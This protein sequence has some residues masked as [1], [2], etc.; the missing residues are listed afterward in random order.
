VYIYIQIYINFCHLKVLKCQLDLAS[1]LNSRPEFYGLY[2]LRILSLFVEKGV[3]IQQ[4]V[5]KNG[6]F[7]VK[8]I[9]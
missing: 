5:E 4:T 9:Y 1:R 3:V 7:Q 6:R 2:L 8:Q